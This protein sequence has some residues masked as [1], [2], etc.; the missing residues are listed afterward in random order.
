[1]YHIAKKKSDSEEN[2]EKIFGITDNK[3]VMITFTNDPIIAENFV[4]I[5][6]ENEVESNHIAYLIE[7]FF[8]T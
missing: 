5:C 1:M 3:D 7:D 8:Y 2:N 6:N 4:K